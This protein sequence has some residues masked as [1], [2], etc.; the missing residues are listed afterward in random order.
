M[1]SNLL[2]RREARVRKV[3]CLLIARLKP[4]LVP[5]RFQTKC[6]P[7]EYGGS[8]SRLPQLHLPL[9][10]LGSS[11][12]LTYNKASHNSSHV[13]GPIIFTS[14]DTRLP[15]FQSQLQCALDDPRGTASRHVLYTLLDPRRSTSADWWSLWHL[16]AQLREP[17]DPE[18]WQLG[19]RELA[20]KE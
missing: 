20:A 12:R 6:A 14:L 4:H 11:L 5:R 16:T 13:P 2:A 15:P 1:P 7:T 17:K 10:I 18:L 9:S 8:Y 3:L 19:I